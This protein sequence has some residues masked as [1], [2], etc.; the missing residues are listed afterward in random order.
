VQ[1]ERET[2]GFIWYRELLAGG[3]LLAI[4][5]LLNYDVLATWFIVDDTANIYCSSFDSLKLLFDRGTYLYFNQ[6]FFSPLLPIAFKLNW[7]LF[8]MHPLGYH[9]HNLLIAYCSCLL[10]YSLLKLYFPSVISWAG[11]LFLAVSLPLSFD[12]AWVTRTHYLW[13]FFLSLVSVYLFIQW[14]RKKGAAFLTFS[15][16][17]ALISFLFKEAYTV[18]PALIFLIASGSFRERTKK[19]VPFFVLLTF[20]FILR[21]HMLGSLGGYPGTADTPVL[22][23]LKKL[24]FIPG[25]LSE[26]LYGIPYIPYVLLGIIAFLNVR[27]FLYSV[28]LT[29]ILVSPFAFFPGSGFLL[30]NKALSFAA[31][32]SCGVGFVL[33]TLILK[34]RKGVL[35][36][37]IFLLVP[38]VAGSVSKVREG[39]DIVKRL[40]D[41][42]RKAVDAVVGHPGERILIVGNYAYYFS[43]LEDIYRK[44]LGTGFPEIWSVS[45][46]V[47]LPYLPGGTF[48]RVVLMEQI[49]LNPQ[50]G[51]GGR[52]RILEANEADEFITANMPGNSVLSPPE[53]TFSPS[54]RHVII[55]I[56]DPREGSYHRCLYMGSYVGCYPI[57]RTYVL[58]YNSVKKI[59]RVD[60]LYMSEGGEKSL[61]SRFEPFSPPVQR[62]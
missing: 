8:G 51:A 29:F 62:Q 13:G 4:L 9:L 7:W 2:S 39:H 52:V 25:E 40:S 56:T 42:Y 47:P 30:A 26:G 3:S 58:Q 20:Y 53:V 6:L 46:T 23:L 15:L 18:L 36:V 43:N 41:N 1:K 24:L 33:H 22:L 5:L 34:T 48:D 19:T 17:C 59:D 57:P 11:T 45:S 50:I 37:I 21:F 44:M 27:I 49:D 60:I 31:L 61:P 14:E 32:F 10:L 54:E 16:F 38:V 35:L 28:L 55:E 12:I